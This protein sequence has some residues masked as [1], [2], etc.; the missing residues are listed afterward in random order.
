[1]AKYLVSVQKCM[2]STGKVEV[3]ADNEVDAIDDVQERINKGELQ[4]TGVEWGD[5]VYEDCS[6]GT[7]GDVD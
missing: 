4:T 7:T 5:M 2:Y 6:F 1:M 3:E